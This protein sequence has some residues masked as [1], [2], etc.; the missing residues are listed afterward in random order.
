MNAD[1]ETKFDSF[2]ARRKSEFF[3]HPWENKFE[4]DFWCIRRECRCYSIALPPGA[5]FSKWHF[6]NSFAPRD[7]F[8]W[9]RIFFFVISSNFFLLCPWVMKTDS[10]RAAR[11]RRTK[12]FNKT[13][14]FRCESLVRNEIFR[15]WICSSDE[16]K[17]SFP[18]SR[19]N[20]RQIGEWKRQL[21][22]E[23]KKKLFHI[24]WTCMFYQRS[25]GVFGNTLQIIFR[26]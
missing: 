5:F 7:E 16:E 13:T 4:S 23:E 17:F 22:G 26:F 2:F 21:L 8:M 19:Q 18:F 20:K 25:S 24:C 1:V 14:N 9:R 6:V 10:R 12:E 15:L 3:I 11:G